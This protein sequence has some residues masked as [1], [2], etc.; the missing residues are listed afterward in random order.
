MRSRVLAGFVAGVGLLA[1]GLGL[2]ARP[3]GAS[4][5]KV[6]FCHRT[7]AVSNPYNV[8][9]TDADS[10]IKQGHGSHTGPVFPA[11]G[12]GDIIP[13]FDYSG[14]HYPGLNW[15]AGAPILNGGCA[16]HEINAPQAVP[17]TIEITT[18]TTTATTSTTAPPTPTT[19]P[20]GVTPTNPVVPPPPVNPTA[21][22]PSETPTTIGFS[23]SVPTIPGV[24]TTFPTETTL[25]PGETT[26]TVAGTT[27]DTT[28]PTT[29]PAA[30]VPPEVT[31]PASGGDAPAV[32]AIVIDPG[33]RVIVLGM[34]DST[35]RTELTREIKADLA[36][37][38]S[39]DAGLVGVGLVAI[40][41]G[42]A[43]VVAAAFRR[44]TT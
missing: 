9:S 11:E 12:W 42:S 27:P 17:P 6:S 36:Q 22:P 37:T 7:S 28:P 8:K 1:V 15:P 10:I 14:G 43:L 32:E 34:L 35:E 13:P 38:G 19:A 20:P 39:S 29:A 16:V 25:V 18:T 24:T 33:D 5:E 4:A 21:P 44:R 31:L 23:N 30:E 3:S 2:W 40:L 26:T 41:V